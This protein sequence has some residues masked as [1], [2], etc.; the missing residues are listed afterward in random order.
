MHEG[1]KPDEEVT[2]AAALR[3]LRRLDAPPDPR[4]DR[5]TALAARVFD[6]PISLLSLV[7]ELRQWSRSSYGLEDCGDTP[8][9]VAFCSQTILQPNL[10]VARDAQADP[11]F[12]DS[13]MVA[14]DP[15]IRFFAGAPLFTASGR[16]VG[17]LCVIDRVPR[18]T[19]ADERVTLQQLA[20]IAVDLIE[21]HRTAA[22]E[23]ERAAELDRQLERLRA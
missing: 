6:V 20:A 23:V 9:E 3:D 19:S 4:L 15:G 7:D 2:R 17:S 8:R 13:P 10:L 18:E 14:G 11:R 21:L 22:R 12:R 5:I 16:A 1:M